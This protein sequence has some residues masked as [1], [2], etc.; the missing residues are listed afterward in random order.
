[1]SAAVTPRPA[2]L[3]RLRLRRVQ[4][5][6]LPRTAGAPVFHVFQE[7]FERA[8]DPRGSSATPQSAPR[9]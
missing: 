8:M 3:A 1:M 7:L 2:P 9:T 6:R 4:V 5:R